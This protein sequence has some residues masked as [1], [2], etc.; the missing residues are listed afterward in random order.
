MNIEVI[1]KWILVMTVGGSIAVLIF[2]ILSK[3]FKEHL[4]ARARYYI[5]MVGLFCFT[6]PW[7][8]LI[9]FCKKDSR[10]L[11]QSIILGNSSHMTSKLNNNNALNLQLTENTAQGG[12]LIALPY[13]NISYF[14]LEKFVEFIG[15]VWLVGAIVFFAWF[16]IR[17]IWFKMILIRSSRECSNEYCRR[18]IERYCN[19][20]KIPKR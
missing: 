14:N 18:M 4:S 8:V 2:A 6:I 12:A 17:Y 1:F 5:W 20:R 13:K 16:L 19:L 9:K 7:N 3:I 15:Y 10:V 11:N